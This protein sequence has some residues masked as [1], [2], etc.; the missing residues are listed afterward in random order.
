M[1]DPP[2]LLPTS[3]NVGKDPVV[4]PLIRCNVVVG[5]SAYELKMSEWLG[6]FSDS[7]RGRVKML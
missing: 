6:L 4:M 3:T 7:S 5:G 2:K 1:D